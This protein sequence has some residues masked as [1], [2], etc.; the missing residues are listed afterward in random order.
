MSDIPKFH[1]YSVPIRFNV[2]TNEHQFNGIIN[3]ADLDEL[4][5]FYGEFFDTLDIHDVGENDHFDFGGPTVYG[6]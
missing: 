2:T 1:D 4:T 6:E 5:E 3:D